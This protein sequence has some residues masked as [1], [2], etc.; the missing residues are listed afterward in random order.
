MRL[1]YDPVTVLLGIYPKGVKTRVYTK[2][3]TQVFV[4]DLFMI[5]NTGRQQGCSVKTVVL[6]D[7]GILFNARGTW[8]IKP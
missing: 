8:A 5:A 6:P 7:N 1:P 4:V 2:I 3:S